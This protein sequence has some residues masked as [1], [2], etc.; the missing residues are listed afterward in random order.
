MAPLTLHTRCR[1]AHMGLGEV[2]FVGQTSFAAGTW[3]GVHLDEPRGKND[4]S[5]Q[6]K[7]Y[8]ACAPGYGVFVRPSQVQVVTN[9]TKEGGWQTAT[10]PRAPHVAATPR[11]LPRASQPAAAGIDTPPRVSNAAGRLASGRA[12]VRAAAGPPRVPGSVLRAPR[13]SAAP[14]G[15]R[16]P[17]VSTAAA[18]PA[19]PSTSPRRPLLSTPRLDPSPWRSPRRL[20]PGASP[21]KFGRARSPDNVFVSPVRRVPERHRDVQR[22]RNA[23]SATQHGDD[24]AP[25]ESGDASVEADASATQRSSP[26]RATADHTGADTRLASLAGEN[27]ALSAALHA[28]RAETT[29][30]QSRIDELSEGLEM[31]TLDREMA[32]ERAEALEHGLRAAQEAAE[33]LR[34]ERELAASDAPDAPLAEQNARLKEALVRLRDAAAETD[35]AQKR[36]LASLRSELGALHDASAA[37]DA[38]DAE[39]QRARAVMEEL[40]AQ[41][42]VAQ[43]AE[44]MLEQLTER[45]LV[46]EERVEQLGAEVHELEALRAV[47]DELEATHLETEAQ[48]QDALDAR[49]ADVARLAAAQAVHQARVAEYE[50]TLAQFRRVVAEWKRQVPAVA[51]VPPPPSAPAPVHSTPRATPRTPAHLVRAAVDAIDLADARAYAA[52][53]RTYVLPGFAA[54]DEGAVQRVLFFERIA[55]LSETLHDALPYL[56]TQ[57]ALADCTLDDAAVRL[58]RLRRALA[59]VGALAA[60][61]SAALYSAPGKVLLRAHGADLGSVERALRGALDALAA[62][63]FDDAACL[64]A[65]VDAVPQLEGVSALLP[66]SS[67]QDLVAELGTATLAW[68]DLDMFLAC[69]GTAQSA[70]TGAPLDDLAARA[71]R[72]RITARKLVRRI[73]G[74]HAGGEALALEA[75]GALLPTLGAQAAALARR[76]TDLGAGSAPAEGAALTEA[77]EPLEALL[78]AVGDSLDALLATA[79]DPAHVVAIGVAAPWPA[80]AAALLDAAQRSPAAEAHEAALRARVDGLLAE[81]K[82]RDDALQAADVKTE[83][84]QHQLDGAHARAAEASDLRAELAELQGRLAVA[85]ADAVAADAPAPAAPV[86]ANDAPLA[87]WQQ[88]LRAVRAENMYLKGRWWAVAVAE[89][90]RTALRPPRLAASSAPGYA[91]LDALR[92]DALAAAAAP[93]VVDVSRAPSQARRPAPAAQLARQRHERVALAHRAAALAQVV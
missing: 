32:E 42:D 18:R 20:S 70:G 58:C 33:E 48:L 47:S 86:A 7:R 50:E 41:A 89:W 12:T 61:I 85:A 83:R 1:V 10:P 40:R 17:G 5:V 27:A 63:R 57:E 45:N 35:A 68:H 72:V 25:V 65:C 93:R 77:A 6:G 88:A 19:A 30:L 37:R 92:R 44:D 14:G 23:H 21:E 81:L 75:V 9:D 43:G 4:G 24:K 74:L 52:V 69:V 46:L 79:V 87:G 78:V 49:E 51:E 82:A 90:E 16:T 34:L 39:L 76:A 62:D 31:T 13:V 64:A 60:Q 56:D 91:D 26:S 54:A 36:E 8:F 67:S 84:L 71:R 55:R 3:V 66:S 15:S 59:H 29:A 38:A 80:R 2:L 73:A 28:A 22:P 53:L 11:T